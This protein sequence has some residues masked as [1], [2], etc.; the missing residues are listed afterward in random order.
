MSQIIRYD[1]GIKLII[2]GQHHA[3]LSQDEVYG[4]LVSKF[5]SMT[6]YPQLSWLHD[7]ACGRYGAAASALGKVDSRESGLDAKHVSSK[8]YP[9][10]GCFS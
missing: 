7:I 5:F 3:L 9:S 6:D 8:F 2:L 4:G 10:K 1:D